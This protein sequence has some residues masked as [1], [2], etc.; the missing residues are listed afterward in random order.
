MSLFFAAFYV[1]SCAL[2]FADFS[3]LYLTFFVKYKCIFLK[4]VKCY[5]L[6]MQGLCVVLLICY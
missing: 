3:H 1:C 2:L 6:L 5:T 4:K